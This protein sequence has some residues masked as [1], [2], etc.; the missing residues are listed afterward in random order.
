MQG[1]ILFV[2]REPLR[3][4]SIGIRVNDETRWIDRLIIR[5]LRYRH[6]G[7]EVEDGQVI[8]FYCNSL[9]ALPQATIAKVPLAV[10]AKDGV[11]KVDRSVK[12]LYS[13]ELVVKRAYSQ[14][15]SNFEGYHYSQNNCE[16]FA[17]WC[18]TG[19]RQS[20]QNLIREAAARWMSLPLRT[21]EKVMASIA[22][23]SFFQ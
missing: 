4:G 16:H 7:I 3:F 18:A 15:N 21:G 14:L 11:V 20:Q 10:F 2:M 22:L 6:Y 23:F 1:D 13:R 19:E 8:H 9:L 17:V 5:F 12:R